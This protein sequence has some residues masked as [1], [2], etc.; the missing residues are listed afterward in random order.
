MTAIPPNKRMKSQEKRLKLKKNNV[1]EKEE[2]LIV[3]LVWVKFPPLN[4][5]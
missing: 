1:Q 4:I 2:A 3:N 5:A